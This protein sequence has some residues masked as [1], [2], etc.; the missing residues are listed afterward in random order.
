MKWFGRYGSGADS[1]RSRHRDLPVDRVALD[2]V[3]TDPAALLAQAAY[4]QLG[5]F[6]SLSKASSEAPDMDSKGALASAAGQILTKHRALVSSLERRGVEA[7]R[8]MQPFSEQTDEFFRM[9]EGTNWH[10]AIAGNYLIGGLLD[11]FFGRL[12]AAV[13]PDGKDLAQV[14][15]GPRGSDEIVDILSAATASD[16][17]LGSKLAV[18]GRR[19][20]GDTLLIARSALPETVRTPDGEARVEPILTELM[21][22]HTRRMDRLGLTA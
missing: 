22:E 18:W 6:S 20:V 9:A 17:R 7:S 11:D 2:D 12:L 19:L 5:L 10:E 16:S 15:R 3:P 14:L 4:L 8:A 13:E 21:A 1:A